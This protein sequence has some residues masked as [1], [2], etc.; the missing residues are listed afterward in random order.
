MSIGI[1]VADEV[2]FDLNEDTPLA[3]ESPGRHRDAVRRPHVAPSAASPGVRRRQPEGRRRQDHH[4]GEPRRRPGAGR[5]ARRWSSTWTRR[6]TR[7]R[8][9]RRAHGRDAVG[10]RRPGR[11]RSR[12]AEADAAEPGRAATCA[13]SRPPSTWPAPR[14]SWS[15]WSPARR[16]CAGR[17]ERAARRVRRT[18]T[19]SSTARRRSACSRVNALV[20]GDEV[21]IPIQCEYYALEGLGQLLRNIE[22]VQAAPQP[23]AA[24]VARSC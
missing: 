12:S 9:R 19:S 10:L 22:L 1:D 16:G 3:R 24:G 17:I 2:E 5:P 18:T 15:R 14:S 4:H 8:A 21:L 7:D 11:R 13:A 20:A 6:A 23:R